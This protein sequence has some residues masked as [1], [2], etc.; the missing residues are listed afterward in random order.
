MGRGL[1]SILQPQ[2]CPAP[3]APIP[4]GAGITQIL[5]KDHAAPAEWMT[6]SPLSQR[7]RVPWGRETGEDGAPQG[8]DK[9]LSPS[10]GLSQDGDSPWVW[11]WVFFTCPGGGG[12]GPGT[13]AELQLSR[14]KGSVYNRHLCMAK[15]LGKHWPL[16]SV[17][18][19]E[20]SGSPEHLCSSLQDQERPRIEVC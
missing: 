9:R 19:Q 11:S 6:P 20:S 3:E 15:M 14:V 12:R 2:Y 16:P 17:L 4:P 10:Q 5:P 18:P 13:G 7:P 8:A 1:L